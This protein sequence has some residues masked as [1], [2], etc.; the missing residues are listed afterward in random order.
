M[1]DYEFKVHSSS[2]A[3]AEEKARRGKMSNVHSETAW[4]DKSD[5]CTQIEKQQPSYR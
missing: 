2:T 5:K 4:S 1:S 3:T